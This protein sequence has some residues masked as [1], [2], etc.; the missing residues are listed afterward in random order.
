[1]N[2]K[3]KRVLVTGGR[4]GIGLAL[5]E[6][7]LDHGARVTVV[8]RDPAGLKQLES[9]LD[10][11]TL[12]ADLSD[13]S[14][15]HMLAAEVVARYSDLDILVNNA[16]VQ[17]EVNF[18]SFPPFAGLNDEITV[19]L[20]AP[21]T[22]TAALLPQLSARPQAAIVNIVSA[23]ALAPKKT[24]PVYC[25][26]KAGLHS[27]SQALRAQLVTT[28]VRVLEVFPPV[29]DTDMTAHR[30]VDKVEPEDVARATIAGLESEQDEVWIGK[31]RWLPM[32]ARLAPALVRRILNRS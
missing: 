12:A 20:T 23:L 19:N 24:T 30:D 7:L 4:R 2:V 25:A 17:R 11:E 1:M 6:L 8:G 16:G 32:L 21:I 14:A 31:A 27:F 28:S 18:A 3:D 13:P 29:V 5:V 26:T 9:R 22:L 15:V 10:V